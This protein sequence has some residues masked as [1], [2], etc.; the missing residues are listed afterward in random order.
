[1]RHCGRVDHAQSLQAD[2]LAELV[3]QA[4]AAAEEER[5]DV[6]L[7]LVLSAVAIPIPT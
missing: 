7:D 6:E 1:V 5:S 3:E 4:L 2:L